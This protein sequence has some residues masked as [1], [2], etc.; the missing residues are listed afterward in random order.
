MGKIE[1]GGG[2]GMA[3]PQHLARISAHGGLGL[4]C[5]GHK[6]SPVVSHP[7][8][9]TQREENTALPSAGLGAAAKQQRSKNAAKRE[10]EK[11]YKYIYRGRE[12]V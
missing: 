10:R 3:L 5:V 9:R 7:K 4:V 6:W 8:R 1:N 12:S 2:G 11:L